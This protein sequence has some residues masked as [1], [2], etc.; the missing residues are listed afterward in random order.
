MINNDILDLNNEMEKNMRIESKKEEFKN[1]NTPN[2]NYFNKFSS[3]IIENQIFCY[4]DS[5]D[6][7]YGVRQVSTDWLNMMKNLW[8]TKIKE[9]MLDQVKTID[10]IYEKE[11]ITKTFEFK[12]EYLLNYKNLLTLYNSNTN[13]F[14]I[15]K[16]QIQIEVIEELKPLLNLLFEFVGLNEAKYYIEINDIETLIEF[17]TSEHN[18]DIY[19]INVNRILEID[20]EKHIPE[21]ELNSYKHKFSLINKHVIENISEQCR[22]IYALLQG[23]IEFESIK[24]DLK[25]LKIKKNDITTK[26]NKT[27]SEWP[28]KKK[29]FEKAY[30]LL[31]YSK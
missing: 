24:N 28:K 26:I 15:I 25:I 13:I 21:E 22:L 9:E 10:F 5:K 18:Y 20:L 1:K 2:Y 6:L 14:S 12:C 23:L 31:L 27:T 30:K 11:V 4:L 19:K 8:C 7:F 16:N 29:F 3:F 17:L